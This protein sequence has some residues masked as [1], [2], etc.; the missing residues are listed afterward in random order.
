MHQSGLTLLCQ[1]SAGAGSYVAFYAHEALPTTTTTSSTLTSTSLT[2]TSLTQ[3]TS[4]ATGP[5][6]STATTFTVTTTTVLWGMMTTSHDGVAPH[7]SQTLLPDL[8]PGAAAFSCYGPRRVGQECRAKCDPMST[9]SIE[10]AVTCG[11]DLNWAVSVLCPAPTAL[12]QAMAMTPREREIMLENWVNELP[13]QLQPAAPV[14]PRDAGQMQPADQGDLHALTVD[15]G[16]WDWAKEWSHAGCAQDLPDPAAK[17][18]ET[19]FA[20]A[21]IPGFD[22]HERS[23]RRSSREISKVVSGRA[24][25]PAL[26]LTDAEEQ[27]ALTNS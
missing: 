10:A 25:S 18:I 12:K 21:E 5:S 20:L 11:S 24:D 16:F 17:V 2:T 1:S 15:V 4:T 6:T 14:E 13:F 3:T 23:S 27:P 9:L 26:R 19:D 7:C 8:P 22:R